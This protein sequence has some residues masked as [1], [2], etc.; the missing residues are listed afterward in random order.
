MF[1]ENIWNYVVGYSVNNNDDQI[2]TPWFWSLPIYW[3]TSSMLT[4]DIPLLVYI[5][6][7][8]LLV[9]GKMIWDNS[10]SKGCTKF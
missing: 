9:N 7:I 8:Q 10:P 3:R 2:F 4:F 6:K 1:Q 5:Q